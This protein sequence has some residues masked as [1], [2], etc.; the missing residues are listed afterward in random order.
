[1]REPSKLSPNA[2]YRVKLNLARI[3]GRFKSTIFSRSYPLWR[4]QFG[5]LTT[6]SGRYR[7]TTWD[8]LA[9]HSGSHRSSP[10]QYLVSGS[11][12]LPKRVYENDSLD[13]RM[14]LDISFATDSTVLVTSEHDQSSRAVLRILIEDVDRP[15]T[16]SAELIAT[17]FEVKA[18]GRRIERLR[19]TQY[20]FAWNCKFITSGYHQYVFRVV[21]EDKASGDSEF[22]VQQV[23]KLVRGV[24]VVKLDHLTSRQ[25]WVLATACAVFSVVVSIVKL[26]I[27]I[28]IIN[29]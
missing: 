4:D 19:L 3:I 7:D 17:G 6:Y 8:A 23:I 28:G 21:I 26:A 18:E 15:K 25:V 9:A 1:M 20:E 27:E 24:K 2:L 22:N 29:L 10:I 16:I 13:V 11:V 12:V 14:K 5:R